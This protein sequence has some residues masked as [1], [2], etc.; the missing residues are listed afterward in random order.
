[1]GIGVGIG[2]GMGMRDAR[3]AGRDR[4]DGRGGERGR[5]K[6]YKCTIVWAC[7]RAQIRLVYTIYLGFYLDSRKR[8]E[9]KRITISITNYST[10][11]SG[12]I[13]FFLV[14]VFYGRYANSWLSISELQRHTKSGRPVLMILGLPFP[15]TVSQHLLSSSTGLHQT[16]DWDRLQSAVD[17]VHDY[18]RKSG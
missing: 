18:Q 1:M 16:P 5:K 9:R 6:R 2:M 4:E 12:E 17:D 13:F 14:L 3:K 15:F 7:C 10:A 8:M 11:C